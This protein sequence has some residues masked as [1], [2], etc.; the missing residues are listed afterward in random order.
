MF[1]Q[2]VCMEAAETNDG[3]EMAA[4]VQFSMYIKTGSFVGK[5]SFWEFRFHAI[6]CFKVQIVAR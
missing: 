4:T 1:L 3:C 2:L 5:R 6:L